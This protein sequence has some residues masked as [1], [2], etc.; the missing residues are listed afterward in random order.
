[1]GFSYEFGPIVANLY[2]DYGFLPAS[3][4]TDIIRVIENSQN[5]NSSVRVDIPNGY[6]TAYMLTIGY[7]F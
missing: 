2:G 7:K 3:N 4:E 5:P 1:V 6:N